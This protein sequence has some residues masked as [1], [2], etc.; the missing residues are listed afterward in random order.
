VQ[1]VYNPCFGR[2][3]LILRTSRP[4]HVDWGH[5]SIAEDWS[6]R[7]YRGALDSCKAI[8]LANLARGIEQRQRLQHAKSA[9]RLVRLA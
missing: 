4:I 8:V 3:N 5:D 1:G 9:F 2:I 6:H 7:S